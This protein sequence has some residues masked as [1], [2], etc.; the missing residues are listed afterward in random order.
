M[1]DRIYRKL[2]CFKT[3]NDGEISFD[4]LLMHCGQWG[5]FYQFFYQIKFLSIPSFVVMDVAANSRPTSS[6][7]PHHLHSFNAFTS[8]S[9]ANGNYHKNKDRMM[10]TFE[11]LSA[12]NCGI[13]NTRYDSGMDVFIL[14]KVGAGLAIL[15]TLL[16]N[17]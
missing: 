7:R 1:N 10:V 4:F 16:E 6:G 17:V 5:K 8:H 14:W 9:E 12:R 13:Y 2:R 15:Y 3:I 11:K